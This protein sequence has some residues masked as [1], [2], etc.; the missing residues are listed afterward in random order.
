MT[1]AYIMSWLQCFVFECCTSIMD[2]SYFKVKMYL[3]LDIISFHV[4]CLVLSVPCLVP[5]LVLSVP[6]LVLLSLVS[7]LLSALLSLVSALLS[8]LLS[9]A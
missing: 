6:C 2:M 8:A 3:S 4:P 5:C 9:L 7:A 1:T